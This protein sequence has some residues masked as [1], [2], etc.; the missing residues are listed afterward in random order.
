MRWLRTMLL[1]WGIFDDEAGD[2]ERSSMR[3]MKFVVTIKMESL[4]PGIFASLAV[5]ETPFKHQPPC[6]PSTESFMT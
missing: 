3:R 4:W 2:E 1:R 6:A 5:K